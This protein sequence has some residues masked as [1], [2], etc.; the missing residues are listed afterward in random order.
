MPGL[1]QFGS[2]RLC[3]LQLES[4]LSDEQV[5]SCP[6]LVLG[7]KIDKPNA[8]GEDLLKRHLGISNFTTGKVD[9]FSL[10]Y[11][12]PY[13]FLC[14]RC[15]AMLFMCLLVCFYMSASVALFVCVYIV[16]CNDA[17]VSLVVF[18]CKWLL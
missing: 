18:V 3:L 13:L 11:R 17:C 7:N 9:H 14:I 6:V 16:A 10:A 12:F 2:I 5:A 8:L 1:M 15:C 4:L